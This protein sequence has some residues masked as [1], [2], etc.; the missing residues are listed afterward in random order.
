ML[1]KSYKIAGYL[2][3]VTI[4]IIGVALI[5]NPSLKF[6]IRERASSILNPPTSSRF[7]F[8]NHPKREM[9]EEELQYVAKNYD[10]VVVGNQNKPM[11]TEANR[12]KQ[13]NSSIKVYLY[14][15]TSI[16]Q[17]IE[18]NYGND[19][20][21]EEWY[22]H[23][24]N[25]E[26]IAKTPSLDFI[27]L[28]NSEYR[29]W[30]ES[31]ILGFLNDAPY[32]G[33]LS[34]NA[35]PLGAE[36]PWN[37]LNFI[38]QEKINSWNEARTN[39]LTRLQ[40][41]LEAR[42]KKLVYNGISRSL[43]KTNRTLGTLEFTHGALNEGFCYGQNS[44]GYNVVLSKDLML[45]DIDL[46]RSIGLQKK[47]VFQKVNIEPSLKSK[48]G[49]Y[50]YG[51]FLMGYVPGYTYFKYG[52][53]YSL[54]VFPEEYKLSP[55]EVEMPLGSPMANYK[56]QD[57]LIY[58]EFKGAW[59]LVNLGDSHVKWTNPDDNEVITIAPQDA[60]FIVKT[61]K[62]TPAATTQATTVPNTPQEPVN[63]CKDYCKNTFNI[64]RPDAGYCA[65][66]E[67]NCALNP[68]GAAVYSPEGSKFCTADRSF[69]CC[70]K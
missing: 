68:E 32:D 27:D 45:E 50:C 65:F 5:I 25:G 63:S 3:L 19:V 36:G 28:T 58:R 69:C 35:N 26:R 12:L 4:I 29:A 41:I 54:A 11:T 22:L 52:E 31:T 10:I 17:D 23:K 13:I 21:K 20:F 64:T 14:F 66:A 53:G 67:K 37:W 60:R 56:R 59:V 16:R 61:Y 39:Y 34:D 57:W 7:A 55:S 9:S 24:P 40:R 1:K 70:K 49:K 51:A 62:P 6:D 18:T 42:G 33:V 46:Q 30:A 15:P 48:Y 38:G 2:F 44:S 43:V 8:I 47:L